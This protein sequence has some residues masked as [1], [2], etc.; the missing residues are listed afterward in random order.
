MTFRETL[1]K[2]LRAITQ[3]DLTALAETLSD[4]PIV[5]ITSDGRL[6]RSAADFLEMHQGWFASRTWRLGFE[7]V[8][9]TEGA[10]L[11][12]AVLR[13]DYQD[14]PAGQA[15]AREAS[16]L[17]LVFARRGGVWVMIQDQNTPVRPRGC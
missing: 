2:H 17:T 4:G 1:E 11:G 3:R 5:V 7:E 8:S 9:V 13:L 12:V 6:V 15:P 10:D 14:E 16:Y